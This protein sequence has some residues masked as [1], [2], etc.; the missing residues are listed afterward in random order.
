MPVDRSLEQPVAHKPSSLA[1]LDLTPGET[2][3]RKAV[4]CPACQKE[5]PE[6]DLTEN[7]EG[8]VTDA[9]VAYDPELQEYVFLSRSSDAWV[10]NV[11]GEPT[12]DRTEVDISNSA[13][14]DKLLRQHLHLEHRLISGTMSSMTFQCSL[15]KS[16]DLMDDAHIS[17]DIH[18]N[19]FE[20]PATYDK[21]TECKGCST[22]NA[23]V[24]IATLSAHQE[25]E[26]LDGRAKILDYTTR[27]IDTLIEWL[28]N[29]GHI[30]ALK[31]GLLDAVIEQRAAYRK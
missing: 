1:I 14:I 6:T 29:H 7:I 28:T 27:E 25:I 12:G 22:T 13:A 31:D 30:F 23:R 9:W 10:C 15:C 20:N 8:C 11:C 3:T 24:E 2:T 4:W 17:Y 16:T 18:L 21:G 5:K 19:T 26:I